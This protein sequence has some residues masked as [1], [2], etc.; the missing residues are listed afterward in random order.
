MDTPEPAV[1]SR[2]ATRAE[3]PG[4]EGVMD[5][6]SALVAWLFAAVVIGGC[7]STEVV[8]RSPLVNERLPRPEHILVHDFAATPADIPPDSSL[9]GAAEVSHAPLTPE[10]VETGRRLGA[11]IAA[12]LVEEIRRMGLPAESGTARA[13]Q[14]NDIVIR[15]YLLSIDEGSATRRVAIGL[16]SGAS[17]LG[18]AVE[19]YQMT[20]TGLRRLGS[21][22][23]TTHGGKSPGVA[24]PLGVTLA[25]GNP[26]GLIVT[27]GMK[28][29]GELSGRSTIEGRAAQAARDVARELEPRFRWQGWIS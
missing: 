15:G 18:L 2:D 21:G 8:E 11:A 1:R 20:P 12:Q 26:L 3:R 29:V 24:A 16:G 17:G 23:L 28:A 10:Q 13:P 25:T 5:R 19:G 27:T 14:V 9:A 22:S 4:G 7:A 6:R